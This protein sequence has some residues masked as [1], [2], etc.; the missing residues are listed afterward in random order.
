MSA[1]LSF[2]LLDAE[3]V[4][5]LIEWA[6]AEGWN[7]GIHD[8][9]LFYQADPEGFYGYFDQQTMIAGGSLVS[10]DGNFG[11]MGLFIVSP[12]YRGKGIGRDLWFL[13]R[14]HLLQRLKP[15]ASIGMDGV[16][17]MQKFYAKGGFEIAFRDERYAL[18]GTAGERAMNVYPMAEEDMPQ[19]LDLDVQCF[20]FNR[21]HFM[22]QWIQQAQA[23]TLV[24][25]ENQKVMGFAVMRKAQDGYKIG[26][27]FA[28]NEHIAQSLYSSC[29]HAA[30]GE[31]VYLDIPVT[32]A[33]ALQMVKHMGATYVFECARMYYGT[34]PELPIE[35][36]FGITSF[37]L[38]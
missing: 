32:N 11:F 8:A 25:R 27:L 16:L 19:V 38:G 22:R 20:G 30:P 1:E 29:L 13:R 28:D 23:I 15:N 24:Y 35:K 2:R 26:P 31:T 6:R 37:E 3:G 17:A 12:E 14:D 33:A 9:D 34:A 21:G 18:Q 4:K 36:I 5:T 10:Y 7:P